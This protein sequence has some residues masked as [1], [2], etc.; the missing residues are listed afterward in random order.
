[1]RGS[2][3]VVDGI[4]ELLTRFWQRFTNNSRPRSEDRPMADFLAAVGIVAFIVLMLGFIWALD[5]V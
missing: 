3:R 1:M 4:D 5:R 2:S